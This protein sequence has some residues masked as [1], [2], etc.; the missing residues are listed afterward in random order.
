MGRSPSKSASLLGSGMSAADIAK[1][2][3]CSV[4]LV[5]VV[6]SVGKGGRARAPREAATPES[7]R[8]R[9]RP[10]FGAN[11]MLD[12]IIAALREGERERD[13]YRRAL[14]QVRAI[15]ESLT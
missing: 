6:K 8:G 9:M 14:E 5:Y 11:G 7:E 1:Q 3:D 10:S 15:V 2:V 4:N 13:R 12:S